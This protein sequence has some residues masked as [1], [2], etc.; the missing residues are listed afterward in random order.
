MTSIW[1][2]SGG[3]ENEK[4][5]QTSLTSFMINNSKDY[6]NICHINNASDVRKLTFLLIYYKNYF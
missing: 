1:E 3:S 5:L 4:D 2:E 6:V